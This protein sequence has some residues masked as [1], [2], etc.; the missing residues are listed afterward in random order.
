MPTL[1][2]RDLPH[3]DMARAIARANLKTA[4]RLRWEYS[5]ADRARLAEACAREWGEEWMREVE[6][7]R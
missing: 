3:E 2:I 1:T 4:W 7:A 6:A 5:V